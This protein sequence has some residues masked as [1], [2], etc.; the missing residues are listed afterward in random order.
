MSAED[1]VANA[2]IQSAEVRGLLASGHAADKRQQRGF[3]HPDPP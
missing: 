1:L 2:E 3:F